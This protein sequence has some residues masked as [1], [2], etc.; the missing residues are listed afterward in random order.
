MHVPAPQPETQRACNLS[1]T[2]P[3]CLWIATDAS[4]C[5]STHGPLSSAESM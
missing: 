1:L 4:Y 5:S 2:T 3:C